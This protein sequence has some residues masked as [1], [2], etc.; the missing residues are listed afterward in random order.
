MT[1]ALFQKVCPCVFSKKSMKVALTFVAG[2][3]EGSGNFA[4]TMAGGGGGR[5]KRERCVVV[6]VLLRADGMLMSERRRTAMH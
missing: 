4:A 5:E 2:Q 3:F 6:V 1:E